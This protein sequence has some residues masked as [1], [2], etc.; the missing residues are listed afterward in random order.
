MVRWSEVSTQQ[1]WRKPWD[2]EGLPDREGKSS[3]SASGQPKEESGIPLNRS[4]GPWDNIGLPD[5][6]VGKSSYSGSG[7]SRKSQV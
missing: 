5:R 2:N 4:R 6:G 7:H 1:E 3:Y